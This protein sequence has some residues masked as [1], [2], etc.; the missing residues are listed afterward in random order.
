MRAI[1][2]L[3]VVAFV[4]LTVS[5]G[6]PVMSG[7]DAFPARQVAG[8]VRSFHAESPHPLSHGWSEVYSFPGAKFLR[9]H[10]QGFDLAEGDKVI[11][12]SVS[13]TQAWQYTG[14]GP[15]NDGDFW[16]FAVDGDAVK[17]EVQATSG[18]SPGF[19]IADVGY[20]TVSLGGSP[21]GPCR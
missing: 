14:R 19:R 5:V 9:L 11:V 10:F 21:P 16:S 2:V 1:N 15:N 18:R 12:S 6:M 17:V 7:T 3:L 20:G 4:I 8:Q 13:G